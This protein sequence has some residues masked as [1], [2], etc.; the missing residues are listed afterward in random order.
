MTGYGKRLGGDVNAFFG[1]ILD[2]MA[3]MIVFVALVTSADPGGDHRFSREFALT[4]MIPGTALGV[5]LGDLAYTWM[6]FRLMR[7]TGRNDVTAMPLGLDT[8]STF[9]VGTLG[10]FTRPEPGDDALRTEPRRGH[11]LWLACGCDG[12]GV[13]WPGEVARCAAG[14]KDSAVGCLERACWARCRESPWR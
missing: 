3:V 12:A 11:G 9:A 10:A 5:L 8:P 6:A 7:R 4:Q 13:D 14:R 1:L 2:N